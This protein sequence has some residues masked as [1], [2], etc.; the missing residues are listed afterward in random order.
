MNHFLFA[1]VLVLASTLAGCAT[2]ERE[3][4]KQDYYRF[5]MGDGVTLEQRQAMHPEEEP[6][7]TAEDTALFILDTAAQMAIG[8]AISGN[9]MS[10]GYKSGSLGD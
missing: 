8:E 9:T 4:E 10:P 2:H 6:F 3:I 7:I 5:H 1:F